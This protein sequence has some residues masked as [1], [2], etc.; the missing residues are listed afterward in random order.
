[1]PDMNQKYLDTGPK[2]KRTIPVLSASNPQTISRHLYSWFFWILLTTLAPLLILYPLLRIVNLHDSA[3][4]VFGWFRISNIALGLLGIYVYMITLTIVLA[5]TLFPRQFLLNRIQPFRVYRY[6]RSHI[7][8]IRL[9]RLK[10]LMALQPRTIFVEG[11]NGRT[12][13]LLVTSQTTVSEMKTMLSERLQERL[14]SGFWSDPRIGASLVVCSRLR[15]ILDS[16][17]IQSLQLGAMTNLRIHVPTLGGVQPSE[18][19][20]PMAEAGPSSSSN[21]RKVSE[22][23][24]TLDN[25]KKRRKRDSDVDPSLELPEGQRRE[26]HTGKL[27]A[28]LFFHKQSNT[29]DDPH[30]NA[31][32][33]NPPRPRMKARLHT[34]Q[35]SALPSI[36][37]KATA[38]TS[39]V[40]D[41][42]IRSLI[43]EIADLSSQLP[44]SVPLGVPDGKIVSNLDSDAESPWN[45]FNCFFDRAFGAD[46]VDPVTGRLKFLARGPHGMGFVNE[47]LKSVLEHHLSQL[48]L[49]LV[50]IKLVQLRDELNVLNS[51]DCTTT[52]SVIDKRSG[53]SSR[54]DKE[55]RPPARPHALSIESI[56]EELFDED[57]NEIILD[58][59]QDIGKGKES[60][61]VCNEDSSRASGSRIGSGKGKG[62]QKVQFAPTV[63][64]LSRISRETDN[65]ETD[66]QSESDG[67]TAICEAQQDKGSRRGPKSNTLDYFTEPKRRDGH[68]VFKCKTCQATRSTPAKPG[69]LSFFD[70]RPHPQ[71]S[72]LTSHLRSHKSK[73]E[74]KDEDSAN[75]M[76]VEGD[77]ASRSLMQ[78]YIRKGLENPAYEPT[79]KGFRQYIAAWILEDNLPFTMGEST[80]LRRVFEYVKVRFALPSDT[81][82]RKTL[83]DIT[84]ELHT[85]LVEEISRVRS[86][87]SYS[88][89]VWTNCQMVFSFSG[90][91]AHWIDDDW[92]LVE[93]LVDFKHLDDHEHA[94][95]HCYGQCIIMRY[96]GQAILKVLDEAE[97]PDDVDYYLLHKD[98]PI[99]DEDEDEDLKAMEMEQDDNDDS[100]DGAEVETSD[101]KDARSAS[102]LKQLRI[103]TTKIVSSPQRQ[104]SFRKIARSVYSMEVVNDKGTPKSK[105]MVIRDVRT[106]WNSTHAMI[107]RAR[108]LQSAIDEW[109]L[110]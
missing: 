31:S 63:S 96:H 56:P 13:S 18:G 60:V 38:S 58:A 110:G 88:T 54:D 98:L 25:T 89:D 5:Q 99:H 81:T 68:W 34:T 37:T 94:G 87:I 8:H 75:A 95:D 101:I 36:S 19:D 27:Q 20:D 104:S 43:T 49:D 52:S 46:T 22:P 16:D 14:P 53:G 57:G 42:S 4:N 105:L 7:S 17:T 50:H 78:R 10:R 79:E 66:I 67:E 91:I 51:D 100:G 55:Y 69:C 47:Y 23:A 39:T 62:K 2:P 33:P 90:I 1:M 80:A 83:D 93:R 61:V 70:E 12:I 82:V 77:D 97:S 40:D 26:R 64:S 84:K 74:I 6:H 71:I 30:N 106:R 28:A 109:V 76:L 9:D 92:K 103:I 32:T 65:V 45:A 11:F 44:D 102:P 72:N 3:I 108:V 35:L 48:P 86:R 21:K 41:I 107:Q 59:E 24:T 29:A 15:H 85:N 73:G